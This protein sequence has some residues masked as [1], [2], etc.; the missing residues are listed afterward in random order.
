[1]FRQACLAVSLLLQ[2]S[3]VKVTLA[4]ETRPQ[5]LFEKF[6]SRNVILLM[7][8]DAMSIDIPAVGAWVDNAMIKSKFGDEEKTR[9]LIR[10]RSEAVSA[11]LH[12]FKEKGGRHIYQYSGQPNPADLGTYWVVPIEPATP[13]EPIKAWAAEQSARLPQIQGHHR[14]EAVVLDRAVLLIADSRLAAVQRNAL[15]DVRWS[16]MAEA[17]RAAGDAPARAVYWQAGWLTRDSAA[18]FIPERLRGLFAHVEWASLGVWGP[19]KGRLRFVIRA[20]DPTAAAALERAVSAALKSLDSDPVFSDDGV[21]KLLA[22]LKPVQRDN[23]FSWDLDQATLDDI[24]KFAVPIWRRLEQ[25]VRE[26]LPGR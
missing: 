20:K 1:M 18:Q 5:E 14:A 13:V 23:D 6:M 9:R 16:T 12:G 7:H 19:P 17:L 15:N 3:F 2:L 21:K 8:M 10:E 11:W 24:V 4:N 25:Y 26:G 22:N